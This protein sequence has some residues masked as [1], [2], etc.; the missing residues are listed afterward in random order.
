[1]ETGSLTAPLN[2]GYGI[3]E[4]PR[5]FWVEITHCITRSTGQSHMKHPQHNTGK[6]RRRKAL[7]LSGNVLFH[8]SAQKG[9]ECLPDG[10]DRQEGNV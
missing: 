9:D 3:P 4:G 1:M 7:A 6:G 8:A 10:A 5:T 2:L